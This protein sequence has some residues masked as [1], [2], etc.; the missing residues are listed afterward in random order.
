[1]NIKDA[2]TAVRIH[3]YEIE[4]AASN[5]RM[6][7]EIFFHKSPEVDAIIKQFSGK[8]DIQW[9]D[10]DATWFSVSCF[11]DIGYRSL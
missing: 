2:L 8:E 5:G 7:K 3:V 10:T 11:A 1:M 6:C 4:Y 9:Q